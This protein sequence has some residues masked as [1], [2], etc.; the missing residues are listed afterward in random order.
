MLYLDIETVPLESSLAATYN[1][2]EH[3]H[4][5]NY[6]SDDAIDRWH[7]ANR[8][9]WQRA[10]VKQAS[11]NPRLGRI[12][13]VTVAGDTSDARTH[14]AT[15]GG[16]DES[17]LLARVWDELSAENFHVCTWNGMFDLR[18]FLVRSV[19]CRV[20]FP[21]LA[22]SYIARDWLRKY[23]SEHHRDVKAVLMNGDV[24]AKDNLGAWCTFFDIAHDD[25]FGGKDVFPAY[26][27]AEFSKIV[28][29]CEDDVRSLRLLDERIT[30]IFG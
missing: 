14:T 13:C 24:L 17:A 21:R 19:A 4:P 26:Q 1:R 9:D 29:H 22:P 18:F 23:G 28:Q 25:T 7:E 30:P 8:E 16:E 3:E 20:P 15:E 5:K 27:N 2:D 10:L 12:F 11:V 6:K